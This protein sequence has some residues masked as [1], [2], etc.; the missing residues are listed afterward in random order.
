[1]IKPLSNEF[2][3][4][5]LISNVYQ[6]VKPQVDSKSGLLK[7]YKRYVNLPEDLDVTSLFWWTCF[8]VDSSLIQS[9]LDTLKQ[10]KSENGLYYTW[11]RKDGLKGF[12]EVGEKNNPLDLIS[13]I[14]A[15]LFLYKF[16]PAE[17]KELCLSIKSNKIV[18]NSDYWVFNNRA[19]WLFYIGQIDMDN[20]DCGIKSKSTDKIKSIKSQVY[21]SEMAKLI[22]EL[23]LNE[24]N[25]K[26]KEKALE[27]L[28]ALAKEDFKYF[29]EFPLLMHHND[30]TAE[31]NSTFWSWDLPYALWLRLYHEYNVN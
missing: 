2:D 25:E 14:H 16:A 15:Y 4:S 20:C 6:Y 24:K 18:N 5:S 11:F 10:Y 8:D 7:Y 22:R 28:I 27:M 23:S 3:V 1:M 26:A 13:N 17:A 9:V 31:V 19:P 12:P 29:T 21:Y 30:I